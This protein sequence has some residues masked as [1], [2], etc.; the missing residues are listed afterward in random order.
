MTTSYHP[1]RERWLQERG[2]VSL[3]TAAMVVAIQKIA[4]IYEQAGIFP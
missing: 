3:R 2:E 1:I 4:L